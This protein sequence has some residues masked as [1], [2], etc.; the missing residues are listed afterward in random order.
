MP[1]VSDGYD[2]NGLITQWP[3]IETPSPCSPRIGCSSELALQS[4][5]GEEIRRE[6][7]AGLM[8]GWLCTD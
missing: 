6:V 3:W 7:L 2:L 4:R 1:R 5:S 8:I